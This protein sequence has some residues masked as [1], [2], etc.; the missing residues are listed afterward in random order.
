MMR[1]AVVCFANIQEGRDPKILRELAESAA[2]VP[3]ASLVRMFSDRTFHRSGLCIVG[4][5]EAVSDAVFALVKNSVTKIDLASPERL[6]DETI[7]HHIGAVDLLPFHPIGSATMEDAAHTSRTVAE[8]LGREL[9]I[10]VL[11]YGAAHPSGRGLAELRRQT[12]FFRR[13]PGALSE[14]SVDSQVKP[15]YGP[16]D[17]SPKNGITVCGASEYVL[18]YNIAVDTQDLT[19]CR[20]IAKA[21][22]ATSDGGLQ[23][24]EAMAYTHAG[25]KSSWLVEVACN[26]KAS[27]SAGGCPKAV[28][29]RV[30]DLADKAG[31]RIMHAYCTNPTPEEIDT[32]LREGSIGSKF[33][34]PWNV[35]P[36]E[37]PMTSDSN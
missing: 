4:G 11:T 23:G 33:K 21:I 29:E 15:D 6:S 3:G 14:N 18:N 19:A 10:S 9:G 28:L 22:R 13:N 27:T 31:F 36:G 2:S 34:F 26:L 30:T 35:P 32:L 37:E 12:S 8:R 1:R 24:V 17:A 25:P 5:P 20:D 7:H 16:A